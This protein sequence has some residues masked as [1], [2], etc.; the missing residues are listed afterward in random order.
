VRTYLLDSNIVS[1]PVKPR[2]DPAVLRRLAEHEGECAISAVTWHEL[3]FG[4]D[5]L[6][7][8]RRRNALT[9]YVRLVPSQFP[10]LDYGTSA[11]EWHAALRA[12]DEAAG[13]ARP[14]ADGQIAAVA[15]TNDLTLVSRN[16]ADFAGIAGLALEDWHRSG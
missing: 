5:R 13:T 14:F 10:I 12:R 3:W 15:A 6:P 9:A 1:E 11:A 16:T 2:P 8:G 4:V 7:P